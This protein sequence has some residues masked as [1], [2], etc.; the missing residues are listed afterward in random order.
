MKCTSALLVTCHCVTNNN[1]D[2]N[3]NN[4][5]N[6]DNNSKNNN[7]NNDNNNINND[8]NNIKVVL[9]KPEK[10]LLNTFRFIHN[11]HNLVFH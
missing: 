6:N 8:N 4:N 11:I 3:N 1:N 2:N 10:C 9:R 7:N 5:N